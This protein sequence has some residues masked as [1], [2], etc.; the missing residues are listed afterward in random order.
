MVWIQVYV[1]IT[2]DGNAEMHLEQELAMLF[3][4]LVTQQNLSCSHNLSPEKSLHNH[5]C[6][7]T[8][9]M[10]HSLKNILLN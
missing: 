1:E 9:S 7:Q 2:I 10:Q 8:D 4:I 6:I 3:N 5:K